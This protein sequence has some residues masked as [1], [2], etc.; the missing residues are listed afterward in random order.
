MSIKDL[1]LCRWTYRIQ[2]TVLHK[3]FVPAEEERFVKWLSVFDKDDSRLHITPQQF[4][5]RPIK[6][7]EE[8]KKINFIEG[9]TTMGG[10]G[11]PS[12]KVRRNEI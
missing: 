3:P 5:W 8:G 4:R 2:P 6:Y 7:P 12:M 9:I 11:G 1:M 10:A